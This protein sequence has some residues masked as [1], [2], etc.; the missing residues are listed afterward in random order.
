M[1]ALSGKVK[2][3]E[4]DVI[5]YL[6]G[7]VVRSDDSLRVLTEHLPNGIECDLLGGVD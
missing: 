4:H 7:I 3:V 5:M 6:S 1:K 2:D